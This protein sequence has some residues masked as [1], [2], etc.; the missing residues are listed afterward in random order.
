M[1]LASCVCEDEVKVEGLVACTDKVDVVDLP[2]KEELLGAKAKA[3][4]VAVAVKGSNRKHVNVNVS[5]RFVIFLELFL[6]LVE[7]KIRLNEWPYKVA[8]TLMRGEMCK[9][10]RH[11]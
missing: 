4:A 7:G 3:V 8:S 6:Q 5:F 2:M 10:E 1:L 9:Q 11:P